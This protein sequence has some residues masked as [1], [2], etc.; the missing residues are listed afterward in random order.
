MDRFSGIAIFS[1]GYAVCIMA[2]ICLLQIKYDAQELQQDQLVSPEIKFLDS[3]APAPIQYVLMNPIKK[4]YPIQLEKVSRPPNVLVA[5]LPS[6]ES[7]ARLE[8]PAKLQAPTL[9]TSQL[10]KREIPSLNPWSWFSSDLPKTGGPFSLTSS[11]RAL[12]PISTAATKRKDPLIVPRKVP[13][14]PPEP[15]VLIA[16]DDQG[17]NSIRQSI[18]FLSLVD[19]DPDFIQTFNR[20]L[21]ELAENG[22]MDASLC[23]ST[24]FQM[25]NQIETLNGTL[26]PANP[27]DR[28]LIDSTRDEVNRILNSWIDLLNG[29]LPVPDADPTPAI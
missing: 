26:D 23:E 12:G 8:T 17:L 24:I 14:L 16:N 1:S 10:A 6:E 3:E 11:G 18:S 15:H 13:G 25:L 5:V 2:V 9:Q 4:D 27:E 7:L 21:D 29:T 19:W 28:R 20:H 22:S